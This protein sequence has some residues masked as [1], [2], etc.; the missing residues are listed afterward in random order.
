MPIDTNA[1]P[2]CHASDAELMLEGPAACPPSA[3]IG[4]GLVVSDTGR[5]GGPMPRYSKSTISD[6]NNAGEVIG[7]G[8]NQDIPAIKSVD[9]TKLRGNTSTTNFPVFPGFPPPE[10]YT[11]IRSLHIVFPRYA[12]GGRAYARAPRTCP[13]SGR[14]TISLEF[15]YHDGVTQTVRSHSRCKRPQKED[16]RHAAAHSRAR[17]R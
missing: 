11:P 8:V 13:A 4:S 17:Q 3:K 7:V 16:G 15:T 14:W 12:R 2:Q 9:H 10:P 1:A 6:F 5:S